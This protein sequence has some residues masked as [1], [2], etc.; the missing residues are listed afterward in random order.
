LESHQPNSLRR[1]PHAFLSVPAPLVAHVPQLLARQEP[2]GHVAHEE[3]RVHDA[4]VRVR[5]LTRELTGRR[6]LQPR[7]RPAISEGGWCIQAECA[8]NCN[9]SSSLTLGLLHKE[10]FRARR[11]SS[12][13]NWK[14]DVR[15]AQC[16][17]ISTLSID[18]SGLSAGSGSTANTSSPAPCARTVAG[19][20]GGVDRRVRLCAFCF[21]SHRSTPS[22]TKCVAVFWG[23]G[24]P[25]RSSIRPAGRPV[26]APP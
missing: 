22:S 25:A 11:T 18:H 21:P 15:S 14:F 1:A 7:R 8:L 19:D 16:G 10:L 13:S 2:L 12:V 9:A 6:G 5:A 4:C 20:G 26:I 23:M 24:H 3:L 17:D